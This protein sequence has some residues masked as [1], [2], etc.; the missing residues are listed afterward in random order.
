MTDNDNKPRSP[1][2]Q[3]CDGLA[4]AYGILM[5]NTEEDVESADGLPPMDAEDLDQLVFAIHLTMM[6]IRKIPGGGDAYR[7]LVDRI[8]AEQAR[9]RGG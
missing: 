8:K 3:A 7:R 9:R 1:R 4:I 2:D 6:E 5:G